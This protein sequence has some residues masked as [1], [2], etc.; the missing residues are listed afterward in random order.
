MYL[1]MPIERYML[2]TTHSFRHANVVVQQPEFINQYREVLSVLDTISDED[3]IDLHESFGRDEILRTPKSISIAINRLIKERLIGM[4]WNEESPIFQD[5]NYN[6][7]RWRLDFAKGEFSVEVAFNHSGSIAWNL[8]KPVLASE[9][10]HVEKA[11]QTSVGLIITATEE[12]RLAG[13]FDGAIGT[14]ETFINYLKPMN[15]ILTVPLIIVGLLPPQSFR[16]RHEKPAPR[17]TIGV[18]EYF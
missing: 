13:G 14:Y 8:I 2:Y 7:N 12:M 15:V 6:D 18:V 16:I 5:R 3:I 11:I 17:K 9:L 4:D 1:S 10:N